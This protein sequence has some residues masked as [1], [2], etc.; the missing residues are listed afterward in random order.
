[1]E[2]FYF[3]HRQ[4]LRNGICSLIFDIQCCFTMGKV[5]NY[6]SDLK[7]I[8]IEQFNRGVRQIDI[9]RNLSIPKGTVSKLIKKFKLTNC[10]TNLPKS[11]RPNK[12]SPRVC[13]LIKRISEANPEK[14]S[15]DIQRELVLKDITVSARTIR[16]ILNKMGLFGRVAAAKP[17]ISKKNKAT[18]LQ[19]AM[20]HLDWSVMKWRTVLWSDES[21]FQI[22][23]NAGRK[24][25]R[26]PR[27]KRYDMKYTKPTVKHGGGRIMVWGC[28]SSS[29]TGPLVKIDGIMDRFVY[30]DILENHMLPFAEWEMPLSW[31]FQQDNDPKHAS[32]LVKNWFEEQ[33]IEVMKWPSQS[34]DLNPIEHMWQ[35]LDTCI[36]KRKIQNEADLW[37]AL[38]EEWA[39]IPV[40]MCEK[41]VTS[42]K[43]R[44]AAVIKAQ[45]GPTKY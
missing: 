9:A 45:G 6:S 28:F 41:L 17:L 23:Q 3:I 8:I 12:C 29:G 31:I 16:R 24:F 11:G 34:P 2:T 39:A 36:R 37:N 1:M 18:R 30:R 35:Y 44:C 21:K 14:S 20:A 15:R 32:R 33:S 25:V 38:Q 40:A 13:R 5:K 42:M 26:R 22:F 7:A 4:S 10:T 19:F 43:K 27:N